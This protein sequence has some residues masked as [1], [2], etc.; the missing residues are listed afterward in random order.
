MPVKQ[1]E[2]NA[3]FGNSTNKM[4]I[5]GTLYSQPAVI[6]RLYTKPD[7]SDKSIAAIVNNLMNE[8]VVNISSGAIK[9][10]GIYAVGNHASLTSSTSDNMNIRLGNKHKHDIPVVMTLAMQAAHEVQN[11]YSAHNELPDTIEVNGS[12][13][14][15]I[16]A[17]EWNPTK[18]KILEKRFT[19]NTHVVTVYIGKKSVVVTLKYTKSKVTQEG[20]TGLYGF[21]FWKSPKKTL[22][23]KSN[24]PIYFLSLEKHMLTNRNF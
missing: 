2:S 24:R 8:L 17:S 13:A 4:I 3:D 20:L 12:L 5:N 16:P 15:S 22:Q 23:R 9:K 21:V 6:K 10:D 18:A 11:Y 14:G 1:N 7:E 19:G